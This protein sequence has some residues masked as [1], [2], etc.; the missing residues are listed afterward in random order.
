MAA[1]QKYVVSPWGRWFAKALDDFDKSSR[2]SRGKGYANTGKAPKLDFLG[3][4]AIAKVRGHFMSWY[5]VRI[6]FLH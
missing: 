3:R 1:A 5:K 4:S 2:L 6:D